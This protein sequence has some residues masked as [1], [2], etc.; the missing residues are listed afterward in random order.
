[1][2]CVYIVLFFFF[3]TVNSSVNAGRVLL[4]SF[5]FFPSF[6]LFFVVVFY[7][8][9]CLRNCYLTK[10]NKQQEKYRVSR[11]K[12]VH[13]IL[14]LNKWINNPNFYHFLQVTV[15]KPELKTI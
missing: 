6:F 7:T 8:Y 11:E 13:R 3:F 9:I 2:E 10:C 12:I 15:G 14:K 1:M 5:S 4:S